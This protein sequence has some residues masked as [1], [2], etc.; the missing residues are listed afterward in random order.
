MVDQSPFE[1]VE[2]FVK[3]ANYLNVQDMIHFLM[4]CSDHC[5]MRKYLHINKYVKLEHLRFKQFNDCFTYVKFKLNI[6]YAEQFVHLAHVKIKRLDLSSSDAIPSSV[7][8]FHVELFLMDHVDKLSS[9]FNTMGPNIK[10]ILLPTTL[11]DEHF[12]LQSNIFLHML[13]V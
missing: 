3:I 5:E 9:F 10:E 11:Y 7:E 4:T 13:N 8:C 1:I 12:L 6:K 2:L